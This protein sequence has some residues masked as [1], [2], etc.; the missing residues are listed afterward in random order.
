MRNTFESVK[1]IQ[2]I[3]DEINNQTFHHHYYVLFDIAKEFGDEQINYVEI[4]CYAG[5][6]ACLM[7]QRPNTNVISIDLGKPI[8]PEV[9]QSNTS[10]MNIHGNQYNYI[11]GNSQTTETLDKLKN[12]VSSVD[13]LFIDGDHRYDG[14]INDFNLYSDLV[15]SGGYIVF[16]D[17]NDYIYSPEVK[18]AVDDLMKKIEGYEVIGCLPNTFD[19]RPAELKEGNCFIIKKM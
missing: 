17:Y 19:A 7:L 10:K 14:V 4:G 6:S 15:K 5:G 13:I 8:N 18:P 9:V 16:D 1:L 3:S 12:F 2:S 11:Q